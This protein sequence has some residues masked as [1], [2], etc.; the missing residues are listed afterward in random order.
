MGHLYQ[1][2]NL[3]GTS[4][5]FTDLD[6]DVSYGGFTWKS[7]GLR[8]EGLGRKVAVGVNVDQQ[9]LKI[10]A[11]PT[12]TL[13]GG[14]F[15]ENAHQGALDGATVVRFRVIWQ[16]VTG[17]ALADIQQTPLAVWP[18]F[19]GYVSSIDKGGATHVEMKVKSALMRLAVNM[20]RN[21]WQ[22]GCLWTLFS[23]GCTLNKS[24]YTI[25]GTLNP[26][27]T[28]TALPIAG[29]ITPPN[30]PD[31][32]AQ[33]AQ[34]QVTFTSGVNEGLTALIDNSDGAGLYLSYPLDQ[35]PSVGDTVTFWVGC[36]KSYNTCK[37]KFGNQAN[38]RGFDKVPPIMV[39]A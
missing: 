22:P 31:G 3:A 36:S 6:T 21:Y 13:W 2:T 37:L 10:W 15:L 4:D 26:G 35:L 27:I 19:T 9:T 29:G 38:Y 5:Y 14:N 25:T 11:L 17:N 39:S 12:D 20:P 24:A 32:I 7:S 8:F 28:A 23:A 16:F 18:M 34:G 30:G 33:F 1:F